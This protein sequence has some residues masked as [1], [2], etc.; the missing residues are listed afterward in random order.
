MC[1]TSQKRAQL[2][3]QAAQERE[4]ETGELFTKK[5]AREAENAKQGDRR[6]S[7]TPKLWS[8]RW[9]TARR[10][11]PVSGGS[12]SNALPPQNDPHILPN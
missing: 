11:R 10:A 1:G 3:A 6:H 7:E 9:L 8:D 12:A 2:Y 5:R 4:D